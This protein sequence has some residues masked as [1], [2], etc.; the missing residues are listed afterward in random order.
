MCYYGDGYKFP[1]EVKEGGGFS[2]GDVVKVDVDRASSTIRYSVNGKLKA[3]DTHIML[4]DNS[5][6]FMPYVKMYNNHDIVEW[7]M[8]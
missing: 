8:E 6:V 2:Q 3:T 7:L 5:R 1:G 4:A